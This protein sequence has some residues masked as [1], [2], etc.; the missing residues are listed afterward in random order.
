MKACSFLQWE[1]QRAWGQAISPGSIRGAAVGSSHL[2]SQFGVPLSPGC[3]PPPRPMGSGQDLGPPGRLGHAYPLCPTHLQL[4]LLAVKDD[5][6]DLLVHEN[7][8]GDKD[9]GHHGH[10][11]DPPR[12]GS[13]GEDDPA[14]HW[15]RG[16]QRAEGS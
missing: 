2:A 7:E 16:L 8:D 1:R 3:P 15:V 4:V 6:C 5:S 14:P 13:K 11:A 10:Q 12:I 9:S